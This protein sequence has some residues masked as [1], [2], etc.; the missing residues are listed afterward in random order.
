MKTKKDLTRSLKKKKKKGNNFGI[1][2]CLVADGRMSLTNIFQTDA[3]SP[4][5]S[6]SSD[7]T[8]PHDDTIIELLGSYEFDV[9]LQVKLFQL[10]VAT[11]DSLS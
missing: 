9:R 3:V 1:L 5:S 11:L 8:L 4:G 6:D 7:P 2:I 10:I